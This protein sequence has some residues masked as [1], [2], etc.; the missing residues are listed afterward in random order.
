MR[1][2]AAPRPAR[3]QP[4]TPREELKFGQTFTD[5][6][7]EIDWTA[8]DGWGSPRIVP[9]HALQL[10]PACSSLHYGLEVRGLRAS[11]E[12]WAACSSPTTACSASRA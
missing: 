10:D 11:S 9:Y 4:K 7:L 3:P 5:H 8:R 6:M 2:P 1:R 12:A